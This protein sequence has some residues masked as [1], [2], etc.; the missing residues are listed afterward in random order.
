[1]TL[2]TGHNGCVGYGCAHNHSRARIWWSNLHARCSRGTCKVPKADIYSLS[3]LYR[4]L[5]RSAKLI[6]EPVFCLLFHQIAHR[7]LKR[8]CRSCGIKEQSCPGFWCTRLPSTCWEFVMQY[9][10]TRVFCAMVF[11][12]ASLPTGHLLKSILFLQF[13]IL[14]WNSDHIEQ[15]SRLIIPI[16][17]GCSEWLHHSGQARGHSS[18]GGS[19]AVSGKGTGLCLRSLLVAY[20]FRTRENDRRRACASEQ[21]DIS[22]GLRHLAAL[23][24]GKTYSL[25]QSCCALCIPTHMPQAAKP[26]H[27]KLL[28]GDLYS[29]M[30][31]DELDKEKLRLQTEIAELEKR[32]LRVW[33]PAWD[34]T[35]LSGVVASTQAS[36]SD[37]INSRALNAWQDTARK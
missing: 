5:P 21:E 29:K 33:P 25:V 10:R 14:L 4:H 30:T 24:S 1:M 22:I 18:S 17:F 2:G 27:V 26:S 12:R 28:K 8:W 3:L 36:E 19:A 20:P 23:H 31:P 11:T 7:N 37:A 13:F 9:S 35:L 15:M 6:C 32:T 16:L 34:R